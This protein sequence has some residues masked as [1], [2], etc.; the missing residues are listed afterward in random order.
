MKG[1]KP[2]T[3]LCVA[4]I[5]KHVTDGEFL[6]SDIPAEYRMGL[7]HLVRKGYIESRY[8]D[9]HNRRYTVMDSAKTYANRYASDELEAV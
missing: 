1:L 7:T 4:Y 2:H 5:V 6:T 3:R 8:H 9:N